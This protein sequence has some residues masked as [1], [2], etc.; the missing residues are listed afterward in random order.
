MS[1][2][3]IRILFLA[4]SHL[5]FD[6]SMNPRISR[7]RRGN[8][9]YSNFL[10]AL[11][12][13]FERKVHIVLH[14]GDLFYRTRVHDS[15]VDSV[16]EPIMKVVNDNIPFLIVPGNHERSFLPR[17]LFHVHKNLIIFDEPKT[18]KFSI[19][20]IAV[21]FSGFP[22]Q[23]E[24]VR[25]NFTE[26]VNRTG[27]DKTISDFSFLCIHQ[28]IEGARVGVHNYTFRE[29]KDVVSAGALPLNFDAV[30][31]GHI[32]RAQVLTHDTGNKKLP[33]PVIYAG[34]IERTSFAEKDEDKG[35][36]IIKLSKMDSARKIEWSFV[37]LPARPMYELEIDTSLLNQEQIKN[38]IH[39]SIEGL[40]EDAIIKIKLTDKNIQRDYGNITAEFLRSIVPQTTNISLSFPGRNPINSGK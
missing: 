14:G 16:F 25:E 20:N 3:K 26:L 33:A 36:F 30:L 6:Y 11:Q 18:Y 32:H 12:P 23:R 13:A 19:N 28:A 4:D 38:K 39:S 21:S 37:K 10:T 2:G 35:Y 22:F 1:D 17:S 31:S 29:G 24:N 9:F 40:D 34:S 7:R 27:C 15:L 5:G 8:D